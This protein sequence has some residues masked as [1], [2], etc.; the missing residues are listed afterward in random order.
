MSKLGSGWEQARWKVFKTDLRETQT[1]KLKPNLCESSS[2]RCDVH[3]H[4]LFSSSCASVMSTTDL[5]PDLAWLIMIRWRTVVLCVV[6]LYSSWSRT[7]FPMFI[8]CACVCLGFSLSLYRFQTVHSWLA[9]ALYFARWDKSL[10][11]SL[12]N[13]SWHSFWHSTGFFCCCCCCCS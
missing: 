11:C 10:I 3:R 7:V 12:I 5:L 13:F 1:S 6:L 4:A 2:C 8:P 9:S